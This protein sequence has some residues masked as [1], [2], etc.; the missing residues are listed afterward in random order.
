VKTVYVV[1]CWSQEVEPYVSGIFKT[2]DDAIANSI[3]SEFE[4]DN[5]ICYSWEEWDVL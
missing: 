3:P 5:G 4:S 2:K 1:F